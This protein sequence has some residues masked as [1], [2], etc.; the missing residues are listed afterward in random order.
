MI[1]TLTRRC[2]RNSTT[3]RDVTRSRGWLPK[4]A[5]KHREKAMLTAEQ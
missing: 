4:A 3:Q 1:R 5:I 2:R